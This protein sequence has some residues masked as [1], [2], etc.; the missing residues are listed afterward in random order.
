M[1]SIQPVFLFMQLI[2]E[3]LLMTQLWQLYMQKLLTEFSFIFAMKNSY[4]WKVTSM[5][6][7]FP[8]LY[9]K[10]FSWFIWFF[11]IRRHFQMKIFQ[12]W[13]YTETELNYFYWRKRKR[14]WW[15]NRS[16]SLIFQFLFAGRPLISK[17][18]ESNLPF[19]FV[20]LA[21]TIVMHYT[22]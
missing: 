17:K 20:S 11:I 14:L 18:E 8:K 21:H 12:Q 19:R 13:S 15:N 5:L 9:S 22:G 16:I 4:E 2:Y 6:K 1:G 3:T 10:F 7:L